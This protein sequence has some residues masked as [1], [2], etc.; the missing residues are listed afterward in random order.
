[1]RQDEHR[2]D[3]AH[4]GIE[5]YRLGPLGGDPCECSAAGKRAG[6]A[7]GANRR[8]RH[9]LGSDVDRALPTRMQEREQSGGKA[10]GGYRA[11]DGDG[12]EFA[13][14]GMQ[15]VTFDD[16]RAAGGERRS[17]IASGGRIGEPGFFLG[18]R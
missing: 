11:G 13:G 17:R 7:T 14:A 9:Q 18:H 8:V 10:A 2:I 12:R 15:R 1:M 6:K 4:F 16:D 5:G 3:A